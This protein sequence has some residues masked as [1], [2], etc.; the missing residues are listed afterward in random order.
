MKDKVISPAEIVFYF[1]LS[2]TIT[3]LVIMAWG[4]R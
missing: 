1:F 2:G 4:I 3:V